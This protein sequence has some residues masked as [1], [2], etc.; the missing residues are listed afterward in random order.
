VGRE[1]CHNHYFYPMHMLM[2]LMD[3]AFEQTL[4]APFGCVLVRIDLLSKR[5]EGLKLV[6]CNRACQVRLFQ[7]F[8]DWIVKFMMAILKGSCSMKR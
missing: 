3:T 4:E 8:N 2:S 7:P 1:T 6:V 5:E